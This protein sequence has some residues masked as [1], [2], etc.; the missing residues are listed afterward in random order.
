MIEPPDTPHDRAAQPTSARIK[1][2]VLGLPLF[3]KILL[4]N[5]LIATV[6]GATGLALAHGLTGGSVTGT[7]L[8]ASVVFVAAT[9]VLGAV[10]NA[11]LIRLALSPHAA[12][13]ATAER[14]RRGEYGARA[15]LSALADRSTA[16]LIR[17]FNRMLDSVQSTRLRQ[18][19]L[20]LRVLQA[21]ER[22]RGRIAHELYGGT[23]Q[24]LAG[25]LVRIRLAGRLRQDADAEAGDDVFQDEIHRQVALALDEIR[26]VARRLRPPE[27][28]ELGVRP[29]LEAHAR[30]LTGGRGPDVVFRGSIPEAALGRDA[31]LALFRITQE[32]VTN[33]VR[34]A[35]ASR[36]E[37]VFEP[38]PTGLLAEVS[39]D[40]HGFDV[41]EL[42]TGT[43]PNLGVTG[44]RE[45][46]VYVGGTFSI[47]SAPDG[48]TRVRT[49]VPWFRSREGDADGSGEPGPDLPEV[50]GVLHKVGA[51]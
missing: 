7:V 18:R 5:T 37:V 23:A 27:L 49:I 4:A 51:A 16:G 45:R 20:A 12:L 17:V 32:A 35:G 22:E 29:A 10:L 39:D 42:F 46:A 3:L 43:E 31:A 33:A 15:P 8:F 11:A 6:A 14:V 36:V 47:D 9:F 1:R 41:R 40:G 48:G 26:S 38:R 21:E 24:T 44:M 34:H 13:V 28:D 19:E 25:V 2:T 30:T 50:G